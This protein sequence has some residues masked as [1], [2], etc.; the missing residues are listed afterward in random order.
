MV[1]F[2]PAHGV[3]VNPERMG[4]QPCILGTRIPTR[5]IKRL[6]KAGYDVAA[7]IREYPGLTPAH[8]AD[9]LAWE[10]RPARIRAFV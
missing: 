10:I 3:Y 1:D 5:A 4:G 2:S 8:I 9:A 7:I 6:A